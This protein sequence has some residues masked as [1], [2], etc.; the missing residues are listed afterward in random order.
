MLF[1]RLELTNREDY[2]IPLSGRKQRGVFFCR[3]IG[4]DDDTMVFYRR[5]E[6][7]AQR[8]G[9]CLRKP[10]SNPTD[11]E[12][13]FFFRAVGGEPSAGLDA[14]A[15]QRA[16]A[17]W[18][19]RLAAE[20]QALLGE[21]VLEM[22]GQMQAQGVNEN[23]RKNAFIKFM[24]WA[25]YVFEGV[26]H[27]A[28]EENLPKLFYEGEI[29]KY[30]LYMLRILSRTGVDVLYLHFASEDSYLKAD[31]ASNYST[32]VYPKRRG[33]PPAHDS[34]IDL[35]AI[36]AEKKLKEHARL[37][38]K[39]IYTNQWM[40]GNLLDEVLKSNQARGAADAHRI[41]NLY[42][43]YV[44]I[45]QQEEYLW[46]L[47]TW[48]QK[49]LASGKPLVFIE[50]QI[51]NPSTEEAKALPAVQLAACQTPEELIGKLAKQLHLVADET[52]NGLLQGAF[53]GS[54]LS[55]GE[56]TLSKLYNIATKQWCWLQRYLGSC[57]WSVDALP[58]VVRY[59]GLSES[60]ALFFDMLSQMPVDVICISPDKQTMRR[61]P[62][63][64]T[65]ELPHTLAEPLPFPQ[66]EPKGRLS[67]V[68]YHAER[69]LDSLLYEDSGLFRHR[70]YTRSRPVTLKTTFDEVSIL[71]KEEAKYRPGFE[72]Q[73]G[74]VVVPNIFARICGVKDGDSAAYFD[75]IGQMMTE[76]TLFYPKV[77]LERE[78]TPNPWKEHVHKFYKHGKIIPETIKKDKAYLYD[79]LSQDTQDYLLEKLQ[80]LLDI[81]WIQSESMGVEYAIMATVL[82]LDKQTLRLI[83]QF[84]FT[85][86]IPKLLIFDAD[87][88]LL[89]LEECIYILFL[90][91]LG[92]DIAVF[93]PTGY[94][95]ID[96]YISRE[97]FEEY[98]IGPYQFQL[99]LPHFIKNRA[100]G[101]ALGQGKGFFKNMF[102]KGRN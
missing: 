43:G 95:N 16:I 50:G 7:Q 22:L 41:Y 20:R 12:V 86:D 60:Q 49:V 67:T 15:V 73:A 40:T 91:L 57:Q 70:Q 66:T 14:G 75:Q 46:R 78:Q 2:F 71:W 82:N 3:F 69:E 18:M 54:L 96:K 97:A 25:R 88:S 32:A 74:L 59:G 9:L 55:C 39:A 26:L 64:V 92:F 89:S 76:H 37:A 30:E 11:S 44:G 83:Q 27:H 68:A 87:E 45:D 4:F 28:G 24:C 38:Q 90:N 52:L 84:D 42:G 65:Q 6:Q 31:A 58:V 51:D 36:A 13:S 81:H 33:V 21:A 5:F 98:Q 48:R 23:I 35:D 56:G 34:S 93:T 63:M 101:Q 8:H 102:R 17:L 62:G 100:P 1:S 29:G 79:Y 85:K 10:I 47:Y 61:R 72:A 94:R 53:F 80:Q 99:S 19:Q 77:P